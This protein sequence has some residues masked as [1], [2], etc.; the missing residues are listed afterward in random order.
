MPPYDDDSTEPQTPED[1]AHAE[2]VARE[3]ADYSEDDQ[4]AVEMAG[5]VDRLHLGEE[6][7]PP[8]RALFCRSCGT[9]LPLSRR[10]FGVCAGPCHRQTEAPRSSQG[11]ETLT[12]DIEKAELD[13]LRQRVDAV[14]AFALIFGRAHE[15]A[16]HFARLAKAAGDKLDALRAQIE[17]LPVY[18]AGCFGFG[19]VKS[20]GEHRFVRLADVLALFPPEPSDPTA[21]GR[22]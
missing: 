8:V 20:R 13:A 4:A 17:A 1:E 18:S 2:R 5:H 6:E 22:L 15:E 21:P 10:P 11:T 7:D 12:A 3:Q 16:V 14:E 19:K 9:I